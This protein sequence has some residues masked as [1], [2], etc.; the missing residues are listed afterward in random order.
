MKNNKTNLQK[1]IKHRTKINPPGLD[2]FLNTVI[3]HY[4]KRL[5]NI[6]TLAIADRVFS[7]FVRLKA[8]N[9]KWICQCVTC[10]AIAFRTNM[11]NWHYRTRAC[12]KYRFDIENCHPQCEKCNIFLN[13]N[14]R[15]YL[16]Y[17]RD[18]YGPEVE[19]RLRNDNETV[20]L[21]DFDLIM[22]C[23]DRYH[24]IE[25]REKE[26]EEKIKSEWITIERTIIF[27]E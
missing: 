7:E 12:R 16:I 20:K 4:I 6:D 19:D 27:G 15:N 18:T 1:Q 3:P 2:Y 21:Y 8:S 23:V 9:D 5:K 22:Q 25:K 24:Y 26:I 14:Y 13:G 11:Q 17:M 10:G